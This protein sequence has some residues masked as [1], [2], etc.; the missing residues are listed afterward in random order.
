MS[1]CEATTGAV[2]QSGV[3]VSGSVL[4]YQTPVEKR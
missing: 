1:F 3:T 4:F 2:M